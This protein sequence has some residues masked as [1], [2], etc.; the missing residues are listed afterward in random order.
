MFGKHW[1]PAQATVV[2]RRIASTSG[3][4]DVSNYEFVVDVTTPSGEVFR[5]KADEP[6]IA[7]DFK[8]PTIGMTVAVEYDPESRKVRFDKD[9]VQLSWKHYKKTRKDSFDASLS[10]PVGTPA[11]SLLGGLNGAARPDLS[12]IQALLESQG[13]GGVQGGVANIVQLDG[14]NVIRMD[15]NSPE[16]AALR[17]SLLRAFGGAPTPAADPAAPEP[18]TP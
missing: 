15:A 14:A 12:Q 7:T 16:A 5:A 1:T 10:A 17:E 2:D 9:D 11:A 6:R 3:D 18:G 13:F 4:G 8:D